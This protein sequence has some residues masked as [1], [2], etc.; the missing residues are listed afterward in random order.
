MLTLILA[1]LAFHHFLSLYFLPST[2]DNFLPPMLPSCFLPLFFS[3][4]FFP[5]SFLF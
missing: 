2:A 3:L 4:S 5:V 1:R